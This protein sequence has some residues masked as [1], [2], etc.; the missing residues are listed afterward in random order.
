MRGLIW[1]VI[2]LAAGLA[3][4]APALKDRPKTEPGLVG[5][6]EVVGVVVGGQSLNL[7][8]VHIMFR[9]TSDGRWATWY[10]PNGRPP[11]AP[12]SVN[13][14]AGPPAIDLAAREGSDGVDSVGIYPLNG[15]CLTI[16][17][18]PAWAGRPTDFDSATGAPVVL[19]ELR[20][21]GPA[22]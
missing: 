10:R 16:C 9:F 19:Y 1:A 8:G 7:K 12:Y 4:A 3:H 13:P 6:W 11:F 17:Q 22:D 21:V 14:K 20:R 15:D 2:A 18:A 5:E